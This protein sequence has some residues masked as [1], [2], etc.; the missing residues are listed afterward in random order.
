MI[1]SFAL[2]LL[3]VFLFAFKNVSEA[4]ALQV[5]KTVT[6]AAVK[7]GVT[8]E[9]LNKLKSRH[10]ILKSVDRNDNGILN[11]GYGIFMAC[12]VAWILFILHVYFKVEQ[13]SFLKNVP[14]MNKVV[15]AFSNMD[16]IRMKWIGIANLVT[17][18]RQILWVNALKY[19]QFKRH[20]A[21]SIGIAVPLM[22]SLMTLAGSAWN[23]ATTVLSL[24]DKIGLGLFFAGAITETGSE[25]QRKLFRHKAE[26][27]GKL[28]TGGLFSLARHIN[29][30]GEALWYTG[31]ALLTTNNVYFT[32]FI[33]AMQLNL[34]I[35]TGVPE[36]NAHMER[37]YPDQWALY[38]SKTPSR[39]IP[40][41]Y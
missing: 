20:A 7:P 3:F 23:K 21:I 41:V 16:D 2:L 19:Y 14:G 27:K 4:R 40:F 33:L 34:F 12:R 10:P 6:A 18:Y 36:I 37:K 11:E 5:H 38:K 31:I 9:E 26:N 1:S 24:E 28:F 22:L 30:F 32:V 25:I 39:L 17:A 35:S 29:Y 13:L 8:I 15:S